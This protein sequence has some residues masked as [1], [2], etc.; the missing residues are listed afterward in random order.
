MSSNDHFDLAVIG[1]GPAGAAAAIM[2]AR[3]G[4]HVLLLDRDRFPRHKVCG[5]FISHEALGLL[6]Q[7]LP[8]SPLLA[9]APAI[10]EARV[11]SGGRELR[12]KLQPP[13][14]S[15]ARY[16]LD[17]ALWQ[18]AQAAGVE[19]R[20]GNEVSCDGANYFCGGEPIRA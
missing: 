14:L 2:A 5:E 3:G 19:C 8:S 10:S 4:A 17:L 15:V 7:L 6:R 16:E 18:A 13:A 12:A 20:D 1:G 9:S 11:Y